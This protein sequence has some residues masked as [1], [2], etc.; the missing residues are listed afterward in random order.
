MVPYITEEEEYYV[1]YG[2][3]SG[4]LEF[5]SDMVQSVLNVSLEDQSYSVVISGLET[6]TIYYG[7]IV[8]AFG[9]SGEYKRYSDMFVF[10]TK[11]NGKNIMLLNSDH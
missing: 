2:L 10:R 11:E 3:D 7:Q 6:A 8:A 1:T 5:T 4:E 9:M